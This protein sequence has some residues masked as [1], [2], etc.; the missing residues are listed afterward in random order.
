MTLP[1]ETPP[2]RSASLT[3]AQLSILQRLWQLAE[4]PPVSGY[5]TVL[6]GIAVALTPTLADVLQFVDFDNPDSV[7][8]AVEA[9]LEWRQRTTRSAG[10]A[11]AVVD[12]APRS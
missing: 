10:V 9:L 11:T 7:A 6:L 12:A 4:L 5:G 3:N 8:G 1:L 2:P